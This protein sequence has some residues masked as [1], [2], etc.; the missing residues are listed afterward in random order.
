MTPSPG[1]GCIAYPRAVKQPSRPPFRNAKLVESFRGEVRARMPLHPLELALVLV[2]SLHLCFLP[3]ALGARDPWAQLTSAALGLASLTL[4]VWPRRYSGE[5]APQGAFIL[6]PWSRLLKFPPF[7]LGLLFLAYITCQALNPAYLRATAGPYWWLAPVE[8]ITWLPSGVSAPFERMNAWRMLAICGGAWALACALAAG[9]TRRISVQAILTAVVANG[10]ILALVGIL[11]KVTNAKEVLWSIK[12]PAY[13]FVST[14]FYKNHAGAYFNLIVVLA[15]ILMVWHHV[16]SIR[17]LDRSSPAPVYAFGTIV[18]ASLVFMSGSRAA[19]LLLAG[20]ALICVVVYLVWRKRA[21]SGT[22]HPAVVGLASVCGVLLLAAA[23][24]FLNLD[25]AVDQ[26][27]HLTTDQGQKMSIQWRLSARA[28]TLDLVD[29]QPLT[30]WGAGS[31]RHT[32]PLVQR[33]YPEIYR[34]G[35]V[36]TYYWDHAHNDYV[37]ALAEVGILGLALPV[38]MLGSLLLRAFRSGA[39]SHPAFILGLIGLGLPLAHA[40]IDFPLY[41]C[42]I[43]VTLCA[44]LVMLVRWTELENSR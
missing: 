14:F 40:W 31:F 38:L 6:H 41:N 34:A 42:A 12:P 30:G 32:F 4:A 44:A 2:A 16:R 28:A 27:R 9:L 10:A 18:L 11:Q 39:L 25:R 21:G 5:L 15:V 22:T 19:M 26:F 24:S 3:W 29:Q 36:Q 23:I 13:Y 1:V 20:F 17:R 7:W 37:Q 8:H 33:N 43:L 35:R